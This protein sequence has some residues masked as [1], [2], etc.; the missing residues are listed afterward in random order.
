MS[1]AYDLG[2]ISRGLLF[3]VS[4]PAGTG[5]TTLVERVVKENPSVVRSISY[6]TRFPRAGEV[7]G[8]D[9][10]F[11]SEKEFA[12][13]QQK[14]EFYE[15]VTLFGNAYGSSK[16]WIDQNRD[17]GK[18]VILVIDIQGKK[19]MEG[20]DVAAS[21]FICPPSLQALKDRLLKRGSETE[22]SLSKRLEIA[23]KELEMRH[24]YDYIIENNEIDV[25]YRVLKSILIA[26][27]HKKG[28]FDVIF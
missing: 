25:A 22:H 4:A 28:R 26:E 27:E 19:M 8:K 15:S 14:G 6:T 21:I 3:I 16:K 17:E 1:P 11:I 18:H 7:E 24:H 9:Y 23:K 20:Q 5:K 2:N 10:F 13:K 12:E